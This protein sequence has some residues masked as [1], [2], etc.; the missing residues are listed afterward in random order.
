MVNDVDVMLVFGTRPEAIKLAPVVK[1]CIQVGLRVHVCHTGQHIEMSNE[2]VKFFDLPIDSSLNV[3]V[4]GQSLNDLTANLFRGFEKLFSNVTPKLVIVHGDTTTAMTATIAS[5]HRS[6]PVYHVEAGLRTMDKFSPFPEEINRQIIGRIADV[7]YA[8][9][10]SAYEN[11]TVEGV[12]EN[13]ILLTGNTVIDAL[14]LACKQ[15]DE[16]DEKLKTVE[17]ELEHAGVSFD[18]QTSKYVLVTG[19]RRENFGSGFQNIC[20]ALQRLAIEFPDIY[21][22]YPVHLNPRVLNPVKDFLGMYSNILLIAPQSYGSFITLMRYCHVI[23]TDSGGVQEEAPS[24]SKP[25][26]VMRENTER[27]ETIEAG[28]ATLV[29]TDE[30]KIFSS[31]SKLLKDPNVHSQLLDE[32]PYGSGNAAMKIVHDIKER[33]NI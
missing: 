16:S 15:L 13:D 8:P 29:G 11:L 10:V 21:F 31:T 28:F 18:L 32:N 17:T 9:T 23:L 24:L 3:M 12:H 2:V 20:K 1:A 14:K 26:L 5:Y 27:L 19:H 33:L 6:I 22:V 4:P 30:Q 7:H 25:V